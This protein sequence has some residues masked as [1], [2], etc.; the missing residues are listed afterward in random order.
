M[1]V[2]WPYL[3]EQMLSL[4]S[5][6]ALL[7]RYVEDSLNILGS[8]YSC[9][10]H[11][12][13]QYNLRLFWRRRA[14]LFFDAL[15]NLNPYIN[16]IYTLQNP[17]PHVRFDTSQLNLYMEDFQNPLARQ[18][19]LDR[20]LYIYSGS[21]RD[22][23]GDPNEFF[24]LYERYGISSADYYFESHRSLFYRI[25]FFF[26]ELQARGIRT[27]EDDT[28]EGSIPFD[29]VSE[30]IQAIVYNDTA[31]RNYLLSLRRDAFRIGDAD[32]IYVRSLR[33]LGRFREEDL[34]M[35][36]WECIKN[37]ADEFVNAVTTTSTTSTTTKTT[38]S[39]STSTT[40]KYQKSKKGK[41]NFFRTLTGKCF[42]MRRS[43]GDSY[44][45]GLSD[46]RDPINSDCSSQ[47]CQMKTIDGL[48]LWKKGY[49]KLTFLEHES[50]IFL[51][52]LGAKLTSFSRVEI[53]HE[54][55]S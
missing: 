53:Y 33:T 41:G 51:I 15:N 11:S 54:K 2:N 19:Q 44:F 30:E 23:N 22:P 28:Y 49:T 39:S 9:D 25:L 3:R 31:Y 38:T 32:D 8:V 13:F 5:R 6:R 1:L 36:F 37:N 43:H 10:R 7:R 16:H 14:Q 55:F 47:K 35:L 52:T 12:Y 34:V 26:L 17:H 45:Y 42:P 40:L 29:V 18:S 20:I 50:S 24:H 46:K 4:R 48:I 27:D 21:S